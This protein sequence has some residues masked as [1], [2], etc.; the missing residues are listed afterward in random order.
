MELWERLQAAE[1]GEPG[2]RGSE[3]AAAWALE[4][5]VRLRSLSC[6]IFHSEPCVTTDRK[7]LETWE[8]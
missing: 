4:G 3:L 7:L 1:R 5:G 2:S 6:F 8:F